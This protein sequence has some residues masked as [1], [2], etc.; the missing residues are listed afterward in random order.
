[1]ATHC[2]P[3]DVYT[4]SKQFYIT[5]S[6][7]KASNYCSTSDKTV[8]LRT[9]KIHFDSISNLVLQCS[10]DL[11]SKLWQ[12]YL[13]IMQCQRQERNRGKK[14]HHKCTLCYIKSA[15]IWLE[16]YCWNALLLQTVCNKHQ[17]VHRAFM[18]IISHFQGGALTAMFGN[19]TNS[20]KLF[21]FR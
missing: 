20:L 11:R 8:K 1:M 4:Y 3:Y 2:F 15:E 6:K 21:F 13:W 16:L 9:D 14:N 17:S 19:R 18:T 5:N 10:S 12:V 7:A